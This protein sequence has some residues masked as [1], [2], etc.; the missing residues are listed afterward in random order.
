MHSI[1]LA[2]PWQLTPLARTRWSA[3]GESIEE[4]GELPEGGQTTVPSDWG[5]LL[6]DDF[7][8]RVQMLRYFHK[9]TGLETGDRVEVTFLQVDAMATVSLNDQLLGSVP[10]GGDAARFE[11][12]GL[13][14]QMNCLQV[15]VELPRLTSESAPLQRPPDHQQAGGILGEVRLEI[16]T[17]S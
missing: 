1:R 3:D 12:T 11:I 13:L 10:A 8:G 4:A 6:G 9:P 16:T 14:E 7:R 17:L 2:G 15:N 5:Q